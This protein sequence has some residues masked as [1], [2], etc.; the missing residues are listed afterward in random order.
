MGVTVLSLAQSPGAALDIA[1]LLAG[2]E[3]VSG[4]GAKDG[5]V[6][7]KVGVTANG[8]A[9]GLDAPVAL[10][11][12]THWPV[13]NSVVPVPDGV[14]VGSVPVGLGEDALGN[15]G[16]K[17]SEGGVAGGVGFG[18]MTG[19]GDTGDVVVNCGAG[20]D[21]TGAGVGLGAET[22]GTVVGDGADIGVGA[23]GVFVAGVIV[24]RTDCRASG[25][26]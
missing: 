4:V 20:T 17:V 18:G 1:R 15:L 10:G 6:A 12:C 3:T 23:G 13:G 16:K 2:L 26:M 19:V 14:T 24:E 22:C 7:A 8:G 5:D 21:A 11:S 9:K 25:L